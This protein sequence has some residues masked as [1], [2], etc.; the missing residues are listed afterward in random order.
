LTRFFWFNS[1]LTQF[2]SYLTRVFFWFFPV[3]LRFGSFF[4]FQLIKPN[5]TGRFFKIFNWIN[6]FFL[7]FGFFNYF[8][9]SFLD[10]INFLI[11]Y[12]LLTCSL[13]QF[14]KKKTKNKIYKHWQCFF[15]IIIVKK[16]VFKK[17]IYKLYVEK[18]C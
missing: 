5:R 14:A 11:F 13:L 4:L 12:S 18:K 17:I 10:L 9:F 7:W 3:W 6:R 2:F 1:V 8:V 15:K 16:N